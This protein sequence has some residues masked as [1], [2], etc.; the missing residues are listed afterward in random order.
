MGM[1]VYGDVAMWR[2]LGFLREVSEMAKDWGAGL[3]TALNSGRK[4]KER[5]HQR[6]DYASNMPE[7]IQNLRPKDLK[8]K[9]ML[10]SKG[11]ELLFLPKDME[12]HK[13]NQSG[14]NQ[15]CVSRRAHTCAA[16]LMKYLGVERFA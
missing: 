8:L 14:F 3:Q 16:W 5:E 1:N 13:L 10:G 2:D 15:R 7:R 4:G 9:R 6:E 12:R 11:I